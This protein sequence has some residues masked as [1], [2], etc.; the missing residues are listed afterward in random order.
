MVFKKPQVLLSAVT[1][2]D[3][4]PSDCLYIFTSYQ[5]PEAQRPI[6]LS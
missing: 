3:K 6:N 1:T 2:E 4:Y 5:N